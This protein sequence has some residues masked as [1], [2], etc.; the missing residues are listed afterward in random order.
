MG[1]N[2]HWKDIKVR[3]KGLKSITHFCNWQKVDL[4]QSIIFLAMLGIADASFL[5]LVCS[6]SFSAKKIG[7]IK[8]YKV[9]E[10]L[11]EIL[12]CFF[13]VTGGVT[14]QPGI[15]I[16]IKVVF[17]V[18][19]VF[20]SWPHFK[21]LRNYEPFYYNFGIVGKPSMRWC[22]ME[23]KWLNLEWVFSLKIYKFYIFNQS[24]SF[25]HILLFLFSPPN[26]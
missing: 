6:K 18:F 10:R 23:Q 8:V 7:H 20:F 5:N 19:C 26:P 12:W 3:T 21:T 11:G 9:W 17:L 22:T 15:Y 24:M 13:L 1:N 16:L 4:K 25:H 14:S 2:V